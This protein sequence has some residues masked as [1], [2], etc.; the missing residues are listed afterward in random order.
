MRVFSYYPNLT[1]FQGKNILMNS[2]LEYNF[3]VL[4][5]TSEDKNKKIPF[6]QLSKSGKVLNPYKAFIIA[7]KMTRK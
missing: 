2:G 3:E 7:E 6:N 1:A 5:P 4:T